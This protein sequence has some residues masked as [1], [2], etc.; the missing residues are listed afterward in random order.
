MCHAQVSE[1]VV[2]W[3]S[4]QSIVNQH[5]PAL[6]QIITRAPLVLEGPNLG[7]YWNLGRENRESRLFLLVGVS[8]ARIAGTATGIDATN[9]YNTARW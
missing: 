2:I 1:E 9:G 7:Q 4:H 8:A 3:Q 6:V 5:S